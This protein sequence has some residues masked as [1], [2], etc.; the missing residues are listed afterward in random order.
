MPWVTVTDPAE[1]A[2]AKASLTGGRNTGAPKLKPNYAMGADGVA[3]PIPGTPEAM[4]A[5]AL[6]AATAERKRTISRVAS[7]ADGLQRD[8]GD[9]AWPALLRPLM[10]HVPG[11]GPY[12]LEKRMD[13][14]KANIGFD[15]L[16]S[17]RDASPTGGALGQ[18]SDKENQLLQASLASMDIGQSADQLRANLKRVRDEYRT[19]LSQMGSAPAAAPTDA[20]PM[21][22]APRPPMKGQVID[23]HRYMGG[24]PANPASWSAR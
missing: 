22:A 15:R 6:V 2:A 23:G 16:Q 3:A 17:M 13:S 24:D 10:A 7:D 8:V 12:D 5:A 20:K 9:T 14:L 21:P 11:T 1:M 19:R 4:K 18:V